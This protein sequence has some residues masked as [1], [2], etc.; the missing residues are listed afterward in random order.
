MFWLLFDT[1]FLDVSMETIQICLNWHNSRTIEDR[2]L[3][4]M[5]KVAEHPSSYQC[6]I[7]FVGLSNVVYEILLKN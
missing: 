3:Q 6:L 2:K 7:H 5:S 1:Y 4:H